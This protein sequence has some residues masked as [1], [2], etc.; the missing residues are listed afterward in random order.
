MSVCCRETPLSPSLPL[1][2][3]RGAAPRSFADVVGLKMTGRSFNTRMAELARSKA[4]TFR[5]KAV[6]LLQLLDLP[7]AAGDGAE[8]A[9]GGAAEEEQGSSYDSAVARYE[10]LIQM[11]ALLAKRC[12]PAERASA[13]AALEGIVGVPALLEEARA[14]V[15]VPPVTDTLTV[16]HTSSWPPSHALSNLIT[17]MVRLVRQHTMVHAACPFGLWPNRLVGTQTHR[18]DPH[19]RVSTTCQQIHLGALDVHSPAP[20]NPL[21]AGQGG[22]PRNRCS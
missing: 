12:V 13:D 4:A 9:G 6:L 11:L 19:S 3:E 14:L 7:A 1:Q 5:A 18:R 17:A 21:H 8:Q 15:A 10:R 2:G 20:V 16:K 22:R